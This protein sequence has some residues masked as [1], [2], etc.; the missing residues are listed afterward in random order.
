M[1]RRRTFIRLFFIFSFL[2]LVSCILVSCK[3]LNIFSP[4]VNPSNMGNDAKMDAGYNALNSGDYDEAIDYFTDVINSS[5]ASDEQKTD[6]YRGR[7]AAYMNK[8]SP[9]L[10]NVMAD[11]ISGDL[12]ADSTSDIIQ[13]VVSDGQ[14]DTFFENV[15]LAADDYN[16]AHSTSGGDLGSGD[17][18]QMYE[19]NMMAATGVG[20]KKIAAEYNASP[21]DGTDEA[22]L[23]LE[24]AAIVEGATAVPSHPFN[25]DTWGD[26]NTANNGLNQHV[27]NSAEDAAMMV[28]LTAA[29]EA[30]KQMK[31]DPPLG[32]SEDDI[33]GMQNNIN[34]WV[35]E[36][37]ENSPLS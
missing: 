10:D 31:E 33:T 28:Y 8:A 6:A 25:V 9:T 1:Q 11:M 26:S 30:T 2:L 20:A 23:N 37:L 3:P 22:S 17:F 32:M 24:Y 4:L 13:S 18:L 7:A 14:Y 16:S 27:K 19:V 5:S 35:L 34:D 12:D 21:W 15:E 29:F 36:G